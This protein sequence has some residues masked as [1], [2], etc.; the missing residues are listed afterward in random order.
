MPAAPQRCKVSTL[1][2]FDLAI[3]NRQRLRAVNSQVLRQ[4]LNL[5]LA[6]MLKI[7]QANLAIHLVAARDMTRLNETFLHHAGSTDVITFDYVE[8]AT[9][10]TQRGES[11][12]G[13]IFICV[14][15]AVA[16]ARRYRTTWQS[17][18]VRY[19]IHGI[20]HLLGFDDCQPA[21]RRRM[22]RAESRLLREL[23]R[24]LSPTKLARRRVSR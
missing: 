16:Q 3:T 11:V 2:R 23:G 5:L 7:S 21:A 6:D 10:S 1:H 20:L 19:T 8:T 12:Q 24:R 15:E 14:D 9:S 18:L 13:E 22:K 17:E 4:M